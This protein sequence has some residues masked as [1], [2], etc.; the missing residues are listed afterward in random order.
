MTNRPPSLMRRHR[1][2][3]GTDVRPA[4]PVQQSYTVSPTGLAQLLGITATGT[5]VAA[6]ESTVTGLP[7]VQ[8]GI[9]MVA[10]AVAAMMTDAD[11]YAGDGTPYPVRSNVVARP[12]TLLGSFEF[13]TQAVDTAMKRGNYVA[14]LADYTDDGFPQ[15]VVPV[16]PDNVTVDDTSGFPVYDIAGTPYRWDQVVHVRHGAPVGSFW[17][18]GVV[19]RYRLALNSQL[20]QAEYGRQS[21]TSGGVPSAHI[22]LD[23]AVVSADEVSDVDTRWSTKFGDGSRKPVVTGKAISVTPLSWSPHDAEFIE[24]R[25]MSVA[26]AAL[27]C[28]LD[29]SDLGASIGGSGL[30]Y[31]NLTDRQLSRIVSGFMPWLRL[32]EEAW[33]D[34]LPGMDYVKGS[35]E[36][37]LRSSTSERYANYEAGVRLGLFTT[38][39]LRELER[40]P[41]AESEEA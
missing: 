27:M 24:S 23:K 17:G 5:S 25:R 3:T 29:P 35:P 14:I 36:A 41:V 38:T 10:H 12:S 6:T 31:A 33:T 32:F 4:V 22:Q 1:A 7:A 16:H 18:C 9:D 21:F 26:E 30:T 28:G 13:W 34:L 15:Q 11:Q 39:E 2:V 19:E 8:A 37:L 20:A 40:R